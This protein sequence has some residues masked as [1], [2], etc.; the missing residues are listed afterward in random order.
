MKNLPAVL[1]AATLLSTNAFAAN[2]YWDSDGN[3]VGNN[4]VL[5]TGLGGSGS[6]D[7]ASSLWFNAT[8]NLDGVW[9]NLTTDNAVFGGTAGTVAITAGGVS[10]GTLQFSTTGYIVNGGQLTLGS[11]GAN[12]FTSSGVTA[13]INSVVAGTNGL[14]LYGPGTLN[15]SAL[16]S[17]T[18]NTSIS[19]GATLNLDFTTNATN[20]IQT[21]SAMVFNGGTLKLSGVSGATDTQTFASTSVAG[22]GVIT[23]TQNAAASLTVDLGAIT[24]TAGGSLNFSVIPLATGV[25]AKTSNA[26]VNGILG[27]WASVGT[28]TTVSYATVNGSNQIVAYTGG[29]AA[30]TGANLTDTTGT[31]NYNLAAA[32]GA[33]ATTFSANTIRYTGAAATTAPGA[34]SF[35]VNGLLNSGTGLWTIG[36]NTITIGANKELEVIT[37]TNGIT[38]TSV[39]QNNAGGASSLTYSGTGALTLSKANTYTGTTTVNSGTLTLGIAAALNSVSSLVV[40]GGTFGAATFADTVAAVTLRNG[41]ITG[42]TGALTSTAAFDLQSGTVSALLAGANGL[43]KTTPGTVTFSNT[44]SGTLTGNINIKAGTL[45][46][47]STGA[48]IVPF[49]A[50]NTINLGDS[51]GSADARLAFASTAATYANPIVL[52]SGTTG[53]LSIGNTGATAISLT[54]ATGITGTHDL[55]LGNT[56]TG[57]LT[58]AN[59]NNV[60]AVT[61]IGTGAGATIITLLGSGVTS[62]N[63]TGTTPLTLTSAW[64][65]TQLGSTV[66]NS[67]AGI[68]TLNGGIT[69]GTDLVFNAKSTGGITVANTSNTG[70]ITNSG[71]GTGTTTLTTISAG[72]TAINQTGTSPLTLTPAWSA[73]QLGS[74]ITNNGAGLLTLSGGVSGGS[75][76]VFNAT[77]T[78]GITVTAAMTTTGT[79]T[80]SGAGTGNV[81]LTGAIPATVTDVVQ[82]GPGTLTLTSGANAYTGTTTVTQG[83]LSFAGTPVTG[84]T[85]GLGN[86]TTPIVLGSAT[87]QGN[88][89]YT[90]AAATMTRAITI[91]AGGGE[92]DSTTA[93]LTINPGGVL[94]AGTLTIAPGGPLTFGGANNITL[95]GATATVP[96]IS[97]TNTLTKV[98]AGNLNLSTIGGT[99]AIQS[100]MPINIQ[101][102]TLTVTTTAVA[103]VNPLGTGALSITPGATLAFTN[104]GA[105]FTL[106]NNI[107]IPNA[108][109][110]AILTASGT[111]NAGGTITFAPGV[112]TPTLQLKNTSTTAF[113]TNASGAISGTGNVQLN[114]TAAGSTVNLS[115]PQNQTGTITNVGASG[116]PVTTLSGAI[117]SGIT[118]ISQAGGNAFTVSSAVP[119]SS[120]LNT[121]TST[122]AGLWTFSGGVTGAQPLTLNANSSGGITVSGAAVNNSGTITNSGTGG[123]V[124]TISANIGANVTNVVQNSATT[125]LVLSGTNTYTGTTTATAGLLS[126]AST[127]AIPG[128]STSPATAFGTSASPKVSAAAGTTLALP[129]GA[130]TNAITNTDIANFLNGT[131]GTFAAGSSLG[132]DTTNASPTTANLTALITDTSAGQLGFTKT[133]TNTLTV[134]P[135]NTYTG[136][137]LIANGTLS[138]PAINNVLATSGPM[139]APTTVA[140]A[141]IGLGFGATTGVL[142]YTGAGE[143]TDRVINLS[144][145]TGGG[146]IDNSG[147]GTL[148]FSSSPTYTGAGAKT[149]GFSG[150]SN[151]NFTAPITGNFSTGA[152]PLTIN[153]TGNGT[154]TLS[155]ANTATTLIV[156]GGTVN[157]G[158]TGL[159]LSNTTSATIQTTGAA[160]LSTVF[161]TGKIIFAG[162]GTSA[163]GADVGATVAGVT[164]DMSGA[165]IAGTVANANVDFFSNGTTILGNAN[166]YQGQTQISGTTL[167]VTSLGTANGAAPSSLGQPASGN[168][169]T[170]NL[171]ST[172]LATS[173]VLKYI[174][175]G[176]TTDRAIDLRGTTTAT[177][178]DQS[179][180]GLLKFTGTN[181]ALGAGVKTMTLQGSTTGTGE[182]SGPIVNNSTTNTTALTKA[183]TGT[184]TLSGV[185]TYTGATTVNGGN[186]VLSMGTAGTG[187]VANTAITVNSGAT[188]SIL[189]PAGATTGYFAGNT[190]TAGAGAKLTLNAGG[191]LNLA[192]GVINNFALVQEG[193]FTG[194]AATFAG[195]TINLDI[196][197]TLG[198]NDQIDVRL[199]NAAGTGQATSSGTNAIA[200]TPA[201]GVTSLTTGTYTLINA[202]AAGSS[203][204]SSNFYLTSPNMVVGGVLYNLSLS[205]T[206]GTEL[207]TVATGGAAAAPNTAYWQGTQGDGKWNTLTGGLTTNWAA[208]PVGNVDTFALPTSNTNVV[209]TANSA[210]SLSTTLEQNFTIN[211][212][213]FTDGGTANAAGSTIASGTGANSLTINAAALNGNAAGN[214]ITVSASAGP[215]LISADVILGASQTWTNNSTTN[216]LSFTGVISG[217]GLTLT[218]AGAGSIQIGNGGTAGSIATDV[219]LV[220]NGTLGFNRSNTVTQGTDFASTISGTGGVTQN[221]LGILNLSGANTYTGNTNVARGTLNISGTG[222]LTGLPASTKLNINPTAGN[223]AVVNYTSSATSTLF[224]I[225]GASVAGTASAY[226]QS[227]GLVVMTPNATTSTQSVVGGNGAYGFYNITGGTL[228]DTTGT[229]GGSRF[230]ITNQG[231]ASATNGTGAGVQTGVVYVSG[232]GFIDHTNAEWWLN[233]SLGEITVADS[234]KIDHTG[235]N[236]PFALFMNHAA[237][238]TGGGYGVLNLAGANSQVIIGSSSLRFGNSTTAGQGEGQSGFVNLASGT[239]SVAA[240]TST[241]LPTN[242]GNNI[243]YNFAGGT[244]KA[245]AALTQFT[246]TSSAA[247]TV[248]NTIYGS[249]NN[250][251]GTLAGAGA[252]SFNGGLNIDTNGFT[253]TV[254][255]GMPLLG[256]TGFRVTQ[257]DLTVSGGSGYIGA[258][259][260]IFS[261]PAS[262]SGVPAAGYALMNGGSVVGIVITDPGV[263]ASGETPVVTL[264]GG[265]AT[266]AATVTSA[267]LTTAN[268]SD[269]G[270][271]KL[272]T[273]TL[274]ISGAANT[275]RGPVDIKGGLLTVTTLGNGGAASTL[276]AS[277]NAASNLLL[278]GGFLGYSGTVAGNTDRNFT[279]AVSNSGLDASGTTAGTFTL[280]AA[281]AMTVAP[282]LGSANLILQGTGTAATGSGFLGTLIADG[283]GT[284]VS[285]IKNGTGTWNITNNA[286]TYSGATT[287]NSGILSVSSFGTAGAGGTATSLGSSSNAAANLV[288]SGG[289]LQY[290]GSGATTDRNY[291]L[292][293][294]T[295]A[296]GGGI[297]TTGATGPLV[298]AGNMNAVNTAAGTQVLTLTSLAAS[299]ANSVTGSISDSSARGSQC[300]QRHD[301]RQRRHA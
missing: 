223:T 301:D 41:S 131:Y 104:A 11:P 107:T 46:L 81:T 126:F 26:N 84:A 173:G 57:S 70:T 12:I 129:F 284:T 287:I 120:T 227:N 183:G 250:N 141:T 132:I 167:V 300:L 285:V 73:A 270:L 246:P 37:G 1:L 102:G 63:Q 260:V 42:T 22:N 281:N 292:G 288:L 179:G 138:V 193:T 134:N 234:G 35:T 229:A 9:P 160:A 116:A 75:N 89:V 170:G 60:G 275:F 221:G 236:Q 245:L 296:V 194:N 243:Y 17:Y 255:A 272:S 251:A 263:Y 48:A 124:T 166:T 240:N 51:A 135:A 228:R 199:N 15:L 151:I 76:L 299:G 27:P 262:A 67:G 249:V 217:S 90:G 197:S 165:V 29:T 181:T 274:A 265:G 259:A 14:G 93:A 195:G 241:S 119:L 286:N 23:L 86:S 280:T 264:V 220:T 169:I 62:L 92:I 133:G 7:A 271:T 78:G 122:G 105:T 212:L 58:F 137:T 231:T 127:L 91:N 150:A 239:L 80:N 140:N 162:V 8:N 242:G 125:Q 294:A 298:V 97:G 66:T 155:G 111:V 258:P 267:P 207:L 142:S 157:T 204:N 109:G 85:S 278:D 72:V 269:G 82:N 290:T 16:N 224:A 43:N 64:P 113:I 252:P 96:L 32:A 171:Y 177:T 59:V 176:E 98:G 279:L 145:L 192:D 136:P 213:T 44:S 253:V 13:T 202:T 189:S 121:F 55:I 4:P 184:W 164:L 153:K 254:P 276:G 69:G 282:G 148:T 188:L 117:G 172:I 28:G 100:V 209:F 168:S 256:A 226:N 196:G 47:G 214:G 74:T 123:G 215:D 65:V 222:S 50:A 101:A 190:G 87:T 297:D 144:G 21:S 20:L 108:T 210:T 139:G 154:L 232:T 201:T 25:I 237:G 211:S 19:N 2:Y 233:Y 106:P 178:I 6:W 156:G 110:T 244:L 71:T 33:V 235:S 147:T 112:N 200:I 143:T 218:T 186:L 238:V 36:T 3:P 103:T 161:I 10:T 175:T 38:I 149:L 88:L 158:T 95:G 205:G 94:T 266:T 163:N 208:S 219:A 191:T 261:K 52:N 283:S 45:V 230:T 128:Y 198:S 247:A 291:T 61:N 180:T 295:T 30:A 225:T 77:S 174:G 40:N 34:T 114:G 182:I 289:T 185:N 146:T 152:T 79:I 206:S 24:Q 277:S 83:T 293:N 18:G 159:T 187:K 39:I 130:A 273:G 49:A 118:G 99:A 54:N 115:G 203:L 216:P 68:L 53:N 56:S 268:T 31:V 5:G 257:T 248:T